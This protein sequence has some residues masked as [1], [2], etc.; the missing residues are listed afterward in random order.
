MIHLI[1]PS[2]CTPPP[3]KISF[4][5]HQNAK[6]PNSSGSV[7]NKHAPDKNWNHKP[8][9]KCKKGQLVPRWIKMAVWLSMELSAL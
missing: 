7:R 1:H 9:K 5:R 6:P 2:G 8:R 3:L 4:K